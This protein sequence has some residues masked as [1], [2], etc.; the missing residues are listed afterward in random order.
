LLVQRPK[1]LRLNFF[2]GF[3][4]AEVGSWFRNCREPYG[5]KIVIGLFDYQSVIPLKRSSQSSD[6][7]FSDVHH[8]SSLAPR[9]AALKGLLEMSY[10]LLRK[11]MLL[12][13]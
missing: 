12:G 11:A 8:V 9:M 5:A 4:G 1:Q 10:A 2:Y 13:S 6:C 7:L 3:E